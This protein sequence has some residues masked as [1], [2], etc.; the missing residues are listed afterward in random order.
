MSTGPA[1]LLML[2][3]ATSNVRD[4]LRA[5]R[6]LARRSAVRGPRTSKLTCGR[7]R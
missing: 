6:G 1:P 2:D 4:R 5:T 3:L 7:T